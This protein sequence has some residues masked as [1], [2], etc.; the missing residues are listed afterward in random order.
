LNLL[1]VFILKQMSYGRSDATP[2][3][4]IKGKLKE[5]TRNIIEVINIEGRDY[6]VQILVL[7]PGSLLYTASRNG[8][9]FSHTGWFGIKREDVV[10]YGN[11]I[12][13]FQINQEIKILDLSLPANQVFVDAILNE[14]GKSIFNKNWVGNRETYRSGDFLVSKQLKQKLPN[15]EIYGFGT[16]RGRPYEDSP[17]GHH[18][19]IAL[20]PNAYNSL[21]LMYVENREEVVDDARG[22]FSRELKRKRDLEVAARGKR[23]N[24][25]KRGGLDLD[26]PQPRN[27]GSFMQRLNSRRALSGLQDRSQ[28]TGNIPVMSTKKK[29]SKFKVKK[30][31]IFKKHGAL[32]AIDIH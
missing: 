18:A 21:Q 20:F 9:D 3:K 17:V 10:Q 23:R 16:G 8:L 11:K 32:R 12:E 22:R 2:L 14:T 24:K 25:I 15:Y 27:F 28:N 5:T 26:R 7:L 13:K 31:R 4:N 6:P 1:F 19:E 29:K 30:D